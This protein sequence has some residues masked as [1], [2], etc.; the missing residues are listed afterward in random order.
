MSSLLGRLYARKL[1]ISAGY[2]FPAQIRWAVKMGML[3]RNPVDAVEAPRVVRPEMRALDAAGV[4]ELLTAV[5]GSE[6]EAVV[7]VAIGTGL[8]RGELLALRWNDVDLE[9]QR[10]SVRRSVETVNGVTRTKPPKTARSARTIALP[11]FV[12][13]VLRRA[14]LEQAEAVFCWASAAAMT[15]LSSLEAMG[16]RGNPAHSPWRSRGSLNARTYGTC[17]STISATALALSHCSPASI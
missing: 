4:S 11:A 17:D 1:T 13:Q 12:V 16:R 10:L 14:R 6:L 7:A 2:L 3:V 8:R 15:V 9:K 5:R